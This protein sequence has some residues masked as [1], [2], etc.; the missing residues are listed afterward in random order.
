MLTRARMM[1][2]GLVPGGSGARTMDVDAHLE[3]RLRRSATGEWTAEA[4]PAAP[5]ARSEPL[6]VTGFTLSSFAA[7]RGAL[8][9]VGTLSA[10]QTAMAA[11]A[12]VVLA[13]VALPARV[14]WTPRER[15]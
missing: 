13:T 8:V 11:V 3:D 10:V 5:S 1:A 4:A 15:P 9:A 7:Q 14:V 12:S 2:R 6:H